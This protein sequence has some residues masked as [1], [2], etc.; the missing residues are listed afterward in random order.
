MHDGSMRRSR[1]NGASVFMQAVTLL[2]RLVGA[3]YPDFFEQSVRWVNQYYRS[4]PIYQDE[5]KS[6]ARV[7]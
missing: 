2:D 1:T 6:I 7:S 5:I 4:N 3:E